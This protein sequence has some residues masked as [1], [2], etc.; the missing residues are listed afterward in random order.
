MDQLSVFT[1]FPAHELQVST[2]INVVLNRMDLVEIK[3]Y[4]HLSFTCGT[5]LPKISISAEGIVINQ[6][7]IRY[8]N[9]SHGIDFKF[10]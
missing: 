5:F 2:L 1:F 3:Y 6:I 4:S 10:Y 9:V 8:P 7:A